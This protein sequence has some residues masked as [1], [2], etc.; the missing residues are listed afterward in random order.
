MPA[1]TSAAPTLEQLL[2]G[3]ANYPALLERLRSIEG[4]IN[5][6]LNNQA[7]AKPAEAIGDGW[8]DA[9]AAAKYMCISPCTFD[10][11]RYR[12]EPKLK[13]YNLDGKMLYKKA[14]L[15][16]FIMLYA[17]QSSGLS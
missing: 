13:G 9:K 12:T 8:L 17:A 16:M 2:A 7:R 4:Q 1:E 3:V 14:D 15:D 6:I 5:Q 11:Y 10:K